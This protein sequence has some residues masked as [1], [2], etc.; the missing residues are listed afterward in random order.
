LAAA[1]TGPAG[2][3]NAKEPLALNDD[4][5]S[6]APPARRRLAAA[7]SAAAGALAADF[8]TRNRHALDHTARRFRQVQLDINAMIPAAL[9]TMANVLTK[10]AA[11][12]IAEEIPEHV[13]GVVEVRHVHA[14]EPG[15]AVAIVALAFFRI[16]EDV[17]GLR[18]FLE[19][20][21]RLRIADIAVRMKLHG[22]LAIGLFDFLV[23]RF[24]RDA[25]YL[26]IV[27]LRA[28]HH[29][30]FRPEPSV[31]RIQ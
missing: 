20:Q 29:F 28:G 23:A 4:A 6:L 13:P 14:V 16:T 10:E 12:Q 21:V 22:Q 5:L 19:F 30:P 27:P 24:P 11:E 31:S 25:E 17:V 8:F 3:L 18:R 9:R 1:A 26:V 7:A 2:L 15:V